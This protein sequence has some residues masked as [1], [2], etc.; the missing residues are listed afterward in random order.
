MKLFVKESFIEI[1]ILLSAPP[2]LLHST[3]ENPY[4]TLR[5]GIDLPSFRALCEVVP[6]P[7]QN[8]AGSWGGVCPAGFAFGGA[9]I[10]RVALVVV[11]AAE[12]AACV[13]GLWQRKRQSGHARCD[14]VV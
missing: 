11:Q 10:L 4:L 5:V 13:G 12:L 1:L 8:A 2:K 7:A 6:H 9:G 3:T 14:V